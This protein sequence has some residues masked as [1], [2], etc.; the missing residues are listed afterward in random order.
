MRQGACTTHIRKQGVR[1][2]GELRT[3]DFVRD[4]V[5]AGTRYV[6]VA[7]DQ[8]RLRPS[9]GSQVLQDFDAVFVWPIVKNL[10]KEEDSDVF[11]PGWL[12]FE[13]IVALRN[14]RYSSLENTWWNK[15]DLAASRVLSRV[16]QAC[17]SSSTA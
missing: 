10:A 4:R 12:R 7:N 16:R 13:E 6:Q 15:T 8:L 5:V 3:R 11:I 9:G 17:S 2:N 14:C 1:R